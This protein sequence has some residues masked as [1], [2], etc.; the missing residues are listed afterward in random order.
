[1]LVNTAY[2]SKKIKSGSKTDQ[3]NPIAVPLYLILIFMR[4]KCRI[5]DLIPHT[6]T[7]GNEKDCLFLVNF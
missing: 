2:K 3:R 1:M 5:N 7:T 4:A 6:S